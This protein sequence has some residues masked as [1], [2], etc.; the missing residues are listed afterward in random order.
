MANKRTL[1]K[2][3]Q[4]VC[5]K[6]AVEVLIGLPPEVSNKI[7]LQLAE[8]QTKA[9]ARVT[10]GFDHSRRDFDS[11]KTFR[12]AKSRYNKIAY[13]KLKADFNEALKNIVSEINASLTNRKKQDAPDETSAK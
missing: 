12:I 7:V 6:A 3:I 13:R 8:L 10:F 1:K 11:P 5:G 4:K 2:D 9:L